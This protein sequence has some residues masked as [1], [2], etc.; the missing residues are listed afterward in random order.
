MARQ[1][2]FI[3]IL[4]GLLCAIPLWGGDH[5]PY[6]VFGV[7]DEVDQPTLM[8]RY[9]ELHAT[10][11]ESLQNADTHVRAHALKQLAELG[12][13]LQQVGTLEA[14]RRFD[15]RK[16]NLSVGG[17][18]AREMR[19]AVAQQKERILSDYGFSGSDDPRTAA[20]RLGNAIDDI[21]NIELR[22]FQVSERRSA[23]SEVTPS[24]VYYL[25]LLQLLEERLET[26][27]V[28][29]TEPVPLLRAFD[30]IFELPPLVR[31]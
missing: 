2:N 23:S 31:G 10:F 24:S 25:S 19:E 12:A 16:L 26:Y 8:G 11:T 9:H 7:N 17:L 29:M 3:L 14:R 28:G 22:R 30:R 20:T 6:R 5:D 4:S 21:S 15:R 13:A 27:L 1:G 18:Q